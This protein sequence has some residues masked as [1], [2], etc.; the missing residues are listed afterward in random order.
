MLSASDISSIDRV[1]TRPSVVAKRQKK[2]IPIPSSLRDI[3]TKRFSKS[4]SDW[5]DYL[6]SYEISPKTVPANYLPTVNETKVPQWAPSPLPEK[7]LIDT[8]KSVATKSQPVVVGTQVLQSVSSP[9]AEKIVEEVPKTVPTKTQP[10]VVET[11]W[12]AS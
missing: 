2:S 11:N 3:I 10:Q 5:L 6:V 7:R 4:I 1:P 9:P 12:K 8:S